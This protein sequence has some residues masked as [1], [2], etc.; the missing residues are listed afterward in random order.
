VLSEVPL[1]ARH[2]LLGL[3]DGYLLGSEHVLWAEDEPLLLVYPQLEELG[4]EPRE[5]SA[6]SQD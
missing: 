6:Q 2:I 5:R 3:I 1:A 4:V